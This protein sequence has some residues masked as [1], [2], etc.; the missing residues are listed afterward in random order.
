MEL[1]LKNKIKNKVILITGGTGSFGNSVI[2][3]L[4]AF[5]PQKII[6]FS[7]DEKKQEDMRIKYNSAILKFVIGDVREE[8]SVNRI[9]QGVDYIFHAAALKQ[10]PTCE[11]F[12]LEAV[13]TNVLGASNVINAAIRYKI[14]RVVVLSTDKAVY[15]I[16]AM[17]M[18]KALMEKTMI[19]AAK[20]I[21]ETKNIETTV[22]GV[23][24]GNVLFTRGSVLPFFVNLIK[25]NKKLTITNPNMTRFLLPLEMAV[26]LVFFALTNGENGHIYIKKSP[27]T[28][29]EILVKAV[30]K[31][32]NYKKGYEEA[33]VRAGE[34][35]HE[36]LVTREELMRATDLENYFRIPPETQ[37]LDYNRHFISTKDVTIYPEA[38]TSKNTV[39]LDV[40]QTVALLLTMP[41][42]Q[43][44]LKGYEN[45]T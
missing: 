22:C 23:R 19:A 8:G 43:K 1:D 16:N 17:G 18:T 31:I 20:N 9:V 39:Q 45:G 34:K 28:T 15:P 44:E 24:Y 26:D 11:F 33:G 4:L 7:R 2:S 37:G 29:V 10:V 12:P 14:K 5:Q 38:Y 36:T 35:M 32:F 41:E 42:I 27:A 13:K 3:K 25:Q 21:V 30:C 6:I 40:E